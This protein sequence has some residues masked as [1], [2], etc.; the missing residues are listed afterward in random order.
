MNQEQRAAWNPEAYQRFRSHRLRPAIDLINALPGLPG[1]AIVDL[2][3]GNGAVGDALKQ[4]GRPVIGVD[5]SPEMLAEAE[6]TG[7]YD[8]LVEADIATW[9]PKVAPALIF[10][11]A[12]LHWLPDHKTLLPKLFSFVAPGGTLAVQMPHQN[13]AP[14]HH[15]W[16][17]LAHEFWPNKWADQSAGPGVL[18]P[19][20]YHHLLEPLGTLSLWETEYYQTLA[21]ETD[22][23]PVRKFTQSTFARSIFDK[24]SDEEIDR[25]TAAYDSVIASAY[26]AAEDGSV[27]FPFRRLFMVVTGAQS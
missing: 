7:V 12:A 17:S 14:S 20:Q 11:N 13:N 2:G 10:S 4:L 8:F 19:A 3:C 5:S 1:G 24:L 21:A 27:L 6:K 23:H 16:T 9:R 22:G 15:I 26:P 18:P 25:L